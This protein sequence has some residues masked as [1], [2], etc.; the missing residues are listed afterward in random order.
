MSSMIT[1]KA[2]KSCSPFSVFRKVGQRCQGDRAVPTGAESRDAPNPGFSSGFGIFQQDLDKSKRLAKPNLNPRA[3]PNQIR[4]QAP[5]Q[6]ESMH[7]A[8]PNKNPSTWPN[9]IQAPGQTESERLVKPNPIAWPN[10]SDRL[11]K[12]IRSPGQTE[13]DRLQIRVPGQT[14]SKHLAKPNQNP[15]AWPNRIQ[16]PGQTESERLAKPNP[17]SCVSAHLHKES[18]DTEDVA[19]EHHCA[20]LHEYANVNARDIV[21]NDLPTGPAIYPLGQRFTHWASDLPTGPAIYPLGQRFTHW[22][23]DLTT[24]PAIYPLGQRFT[25]WASEF[26]TGSANYPLGQRITLW[27][28][29]LPSGP[30]NFPLGQRIYLWANEFTSGPTN[31]PLGQRIYL[32]AN[33]FPSG[34]ANFPLGLQITGQ[35]ATLNTG[36]ICLSLCGGYTTPG[37]SNWRP[38]GRIPALGTIE[39][40]QHCTTPWSKCLYSANFPLDQGHI[41]Y[42]SCS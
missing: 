7:L 18:E 4:I 13:S 11:A 30:A 28:S 34:P 6:T 31:L 3:W 22:A 5:G 38:I 23:S 17:E 16:A 19:H 42:K 26:P 24:G 35:E 40:G 32:W 2:T 14:E 20:T 8:K 12:R 27:A 29:E 21:F 33:E 41:D 36:F 10:E 37:L 15:C 1:H 25:H 39:V 9:R